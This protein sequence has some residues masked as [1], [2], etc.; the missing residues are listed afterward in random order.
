MDFSKINVLGIDIFCKDLMARDVPYA[1]V[2]KDFGADNTGESD[3][4]AS[5]QSAVNQSHSS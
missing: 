1:D 5:V 4:T 3:T 2:V